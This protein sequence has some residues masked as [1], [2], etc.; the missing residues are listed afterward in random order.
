MSY[1]KSWRLAAA[2]YYQCRHCC[3]LIEQGA[4]GFVVKP[5]VENLARY[6]VRR[7]A[8]TCMGHAMGA[9]GQAT[10]ELMYRSEAVRWPAPVAG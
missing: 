6:V 4:S 2:G 1:W 5:D 9:R 7:A 10:I 3:D 8:D